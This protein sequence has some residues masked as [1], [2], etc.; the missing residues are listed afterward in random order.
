MRKRKKLKKEK[1]IDTRYVRRYSRG[2]SPV[3][4]FIPIEDLPPGAF[5][6]KPT[7]DTSSTNANSNTTNK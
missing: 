4:E 6:S 2:Y 5:N 3:G 1:T 7:S